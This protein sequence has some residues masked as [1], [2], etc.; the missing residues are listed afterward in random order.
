MCNGMESN[1]VRLKIL[2]RPSICSSRRYLNPPFNL[3]WQ[4]LY[5]SDHFDCVS[6]D[7][8]FTIDEVKAVV[9]S[10]KRNSYCT[11]RGAE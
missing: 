9:D 6:L 4:Q 11:A 10:F 1:S 2:K 5:S 3:D 8:Q 7:N